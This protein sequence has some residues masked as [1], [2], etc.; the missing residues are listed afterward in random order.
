MESETVTVDLSLNPVPYIEN[1]TLPL[2]GNLSIL[3][4]NIDSEFSPTS[5][6][7]VLLFIDSFINVI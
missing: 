3:V 1:V 6:A 5:I 2:F 4:P 7:A